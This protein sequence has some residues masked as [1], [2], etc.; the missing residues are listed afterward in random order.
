MLYITY[1]LAN[2]FALAHSFLLCQMVTPPPPGYNC[3]SPFMFLAIVIHLPTRIAV[4]FESSLY[5]HVVYFLNRDPRCRWHPSC[6]GGCFVVLWVVFERGLIVVMGDVVI[7]DVVV[8]VVVV[9]FP[10]QMGLLRRSH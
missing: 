3:P 2:S 4:L 9:V 6:G 7:R 10:M 5:F 8:G 1:A